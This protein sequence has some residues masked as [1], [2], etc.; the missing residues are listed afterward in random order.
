MLNNYLIDIIIAML[1]INASHNKLLYTII[2]T[3]YKITTT[4]NSTLQ[5]LTIS[6]F[7]VLQ[8]NEN[9]VGVHNFFSQCRKISEMNYN[10]VSHC[11][12]LCEMKYNFISQYRKFCG[13]RLCIPNFLKFTAVF[14]ST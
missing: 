14:C 9:F 10:F 8:S 5:K 2:Y 4:S 11:Q 1:N 12:K 7:K 13:Y 6:K 3:L